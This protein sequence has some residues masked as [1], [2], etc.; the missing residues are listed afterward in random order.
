[1]GCL[2]RTPDT[3]PKARS[4]AGDHRLTSTTRGTT[5]FGSLDVFPVRSSAGIVA[6]D[7]MPGRVIEVQ[8]VAVDVNSGSRLAWWLAA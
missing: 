3:L 2:G 4:Q 5:S 8:R 7:V 6:G 1:L